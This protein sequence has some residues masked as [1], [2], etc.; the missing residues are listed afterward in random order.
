MSTRAPVDQGP[1]DY[2][3]VRAT[4]DETTLSY[5][6][7]DVSNP[8]AQL[9]AVRDGPFVDFWLKPDGEPWEVQFTLEQSV[10]LRLLGDAE[11]ASLAK[12]PGAAA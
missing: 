5:L 8:A 12:R 11:A 9:W 3:A 7:S 6:G 10:L 1:G 4:I 2:R